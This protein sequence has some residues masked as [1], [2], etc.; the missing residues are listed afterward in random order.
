MEEVR[1]EESGRTTVLGTISTMTFTLS[2]PSSNL[3]EQSMTDQ[4]AIVPVGG[5]GDSWT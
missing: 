1:E 4:S 3:S 5:G 2:F